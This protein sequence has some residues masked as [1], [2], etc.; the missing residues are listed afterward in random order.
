MRAHGKVSL[1]STAL[2]AAVAGGIYWVVIFAPVYLDN[3]D[4]KDVVSACYNDSG[5]ANDEML[6]RRI[7]EVAER[8]GTHQAE[9]GFGRLIDA[10]GLG[11]DPEQI[12]LFRDEVRGT[13]LIQVEY[14][15]EVQLKPLQ[16]K[17]R[18]HFST[19]KEGP[20]PTQ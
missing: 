14:D 15:Q 18:I 5:R 6:R 20:V 11:L 16:K 1:V 13:I 9:D 10:P 8:V 19:V 7:T 3:L 2:M 12:T 17:Q 4:I